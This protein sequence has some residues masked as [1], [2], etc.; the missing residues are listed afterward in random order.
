MKITLESTSKIVELQIRP[1]AA[2]PARVWEGH[3]EGGIPCFA[4][5][6]R[7][8]PAIPADQLT[9]EQDAEFQRD[10]AEQRAPSPAVQAFDMR[11]IL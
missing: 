9:A 5:I 6:T 1:G 2:V 8:A 7:I 3:T 10:L 11:L 4:F